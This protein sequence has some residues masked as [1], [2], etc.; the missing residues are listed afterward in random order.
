VVFLGVSVEICP[1]CLL[2]TNILN[3]L[4]VSCKFPLLMHSNRVKLK[5]IGEM[6][7]ASTLCS[8][9]YPQSLTHTQIHLY[10]CD[11]FSQTTPTHEISMLELEE[12]II[13][14]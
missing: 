6:E 1:N 14:Q 9:F 3:H 5:R 8:N 12:I 11:N 4:E 13:N 10:A 7:E 2:L